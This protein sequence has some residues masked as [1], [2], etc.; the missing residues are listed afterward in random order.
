MILPFGSGS[1][2]LPLPIFDES[3]KFVL[4][5]GTVFQATSGIIEVFA[6]SPDT[7]Q[8]VGYLQADFDED[9]SVQGRFIIDLC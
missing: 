8:L 7:Q 4:G 6:I 5:D 9:N 1:Y 3:V 2:S